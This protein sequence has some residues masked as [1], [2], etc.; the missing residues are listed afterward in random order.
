MSVKLR[1][2]NELLMCTTI[3]RA[4]KP[5]P[6]LTIGWLYDFSEKAKACLSS[7]LQSDQTE[8]LWMGTE[9]GDIRNTSIDIG[10]VPQSHLVP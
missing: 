7:P 10:E 2:D 1:T 3:L 6:T 5:E 8:R 4:S 9:G